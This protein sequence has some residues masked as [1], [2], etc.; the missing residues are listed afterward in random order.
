MMFPINFSIFLS[1][2]MQNFCVS[3]GQI[4]IVNGVRSNCL[5]SEI[6][7]YLE[8]IHIKLIYFILNSIYVVISLHP[9]QVSM[10][11]ERALRKHPINGHGKYK[12]KPTRQTSARGLAKK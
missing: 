11:G 12:G 2:M 5:R 8:Q 10:V 7:G 3:R 4:W 6:I 9:R 1:Y